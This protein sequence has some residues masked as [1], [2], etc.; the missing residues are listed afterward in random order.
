ME[1]RK[2]SLANLVD[3]F[4]TVDRVVYIDKYGRVNEHN[5]FK[6]IG[7]DLYIENFDTEGTYKLM[8]K[9]KL[10]RVTSATDNNFELNVPDHIAC[11]IPYF[12][13]GDLFQAD[14]PNL[15]SESRSYWEQATVAMRPDK[16]AYQSEVDTSFSVDW[17]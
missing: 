5:P 13:K 3:D 2:W 10:T 6:L 16:T 17:S 4:R 11:L 14:E 15:A 12:V 1:T 8:Y 7:T 9:T